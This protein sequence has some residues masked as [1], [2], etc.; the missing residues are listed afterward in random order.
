LTID[1]AMPHLVS[2]TDPKPQFL[3]CSEANVELNTGA[4]VRV[5]DGRIWTAPDEK[6]LV[7]L[8]VGPTSELYVV[9]NPA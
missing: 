3:R 4:I 9:S 8:N 1:L 2:A 7:T 5:V 6:G